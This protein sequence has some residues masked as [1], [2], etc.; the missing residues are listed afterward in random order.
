MNKQAVFL[1][2]SI[3]SSTLSIIEI[4]VL[5]V[6]RFCFIHDVKLAICDPWV[7]DFSIYCS[8]M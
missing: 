6:V 1:E 7:L 5:I 3:E 8:S 4:N 2:K